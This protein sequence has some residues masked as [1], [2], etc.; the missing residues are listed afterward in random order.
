MQEIESIISKRDS[1]TLLDIIYECSLCSTTQAAHAIIQKTNTLIDFDNSIYALAKLNTDVSITNYD[2]INFSYPQEWID[3]YKNKNFY[4]KDPVVLNTFNNFGLQY[5]ADT[6]KNYTI[7]TDFMH[8]SGDFN[9]SNGYSCSTINPSK[10]EGSLLSFAGDIT[11]HPRIDYILEHLSS[12]F[13]VAFSNLLRTQNN[14]KILTQVSLREKEVLNWI[15]HGKSTWDISAI[16]K[17]SERTVKFHID[18]IMKK[19]DAVNRP[20][21]VAIALSNG[22][23]N[24]D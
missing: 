4:E 7:D 10:A 23:I 15:K 3:I 22:L 2:I 18:N 6:Y 16:L 17:I 11:K 5:W 21:A 24:F 12:H 9:L 13:H 20:H 14:N 8:I 19:L 1:L